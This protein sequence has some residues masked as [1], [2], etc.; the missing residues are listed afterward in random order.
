MRTTHFLFLSLFFLFLF[1]PFLHIPCSLDVTE[2]PSY[3]TFFI[4][5]V[6][7]CFCAEISRVSFQ[8]ELSLPHLSAG[9]LRW[10][11]YKELL[12]E[13]EM[14]MSVDE[15]RLYLLENLVWGH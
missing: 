15:D 1:F 9:S 5:S 7:F 10:L 2:M 13:S 3:Q 14:Y 6:C 4:Q 12:N 11:S 8:A